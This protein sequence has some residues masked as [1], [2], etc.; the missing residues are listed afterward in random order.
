MEI[1]DKDFSQYID[2]V[3]A[4]GSCKKQDVFLSKNES[5]ALVIATTPPDPLHGVN[6]C[7]FFLF[8]KDI[9]KSEG[10]LF[11]DSPYQGEDFYYAD[12]LLAKIS[13]VEEK[14]N[15]EAVVLVQKSNGKE[16]EFKLKNLI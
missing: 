15:G 7:Y 8:F 6:R 12:N 4:K 5:F 2:S 3:L 10:V 11:Y 14:D 1:K 9:K 13:S 16:K